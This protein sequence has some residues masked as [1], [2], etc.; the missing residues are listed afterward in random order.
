MR[1]ETIGRLLVATAVDARGSEVLYMVSRDQLYGDLR[2]CN[3]VSGL[4]G[5]SKH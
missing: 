5:L 4:D 3:V 1:M 2:H